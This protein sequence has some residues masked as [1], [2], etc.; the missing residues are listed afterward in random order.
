MEARNL[1]SLIQSSWEQLSQTTD[2]APSQ[3][4]FKTLNTTYEIRYKEIENMEPFDDTK[5]IQDVWENVYKFMVASDPSINHKW[6]QDVKNW[7]VTQYRGQL[8]QHKQNI[9]NL[10]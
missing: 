7:F 3:E 4:Y 10:L 9:S 1:F 2:N 5:S 6:N 8:P